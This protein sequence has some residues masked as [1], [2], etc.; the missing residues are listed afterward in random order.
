MADMY[1]TSEQQKATA[2]AGA[3][4]AA[5]NRTLADLDARIKQ[6]AADVTSGI[7]AGMTPQELADKNA[8]LDA[9]KTQAEAVTRGVQGGYEFVRQE[10]D[11][12]AEQTARQ[13]AEAQAQQA[14]MARAAIQSTAG[15]GTRSGL[16]QP[17]VADATR[18]QE[19][20][21]AATQAYL[22]G[23]LSVAPEMLPRVQGLGTST[24]A[25]L[26]LA[27]IS[28]ADSSAF[29][30]AMTAVEAQTLAEIARDKMMLG[31]QIESSFRKEA[32]DR[33]ANQRQQAQAQVNQ[34]TQMLL[35]QQAQAALTQSQLE[36]AA[37]GADTRTGKQKAQAELETFK[38]QER[39]RH[40]YAMREIAARGQE[41]GLSPSQ[42]AQ[43][44]SI[45]NQQAGRNTYLNDML[46][47]AQARSYINAL[48]KSAVEAATA[49]SKFYSDGVTVYYAPNGAEGDSVPVNVQALQTALIEQAGATKNLPDVKQRQEAFAQWYTQ[50]DPAS[51]LFLKQWLGSVA[52]QLNVVAIDS[53]T[54]KTQAYN[55]SDPNTIYR[56]IM[57]PSVIRR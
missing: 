52:K 32:R 21:A 29:T 13:L 17:S 12:T 18:A 54:K 41:A 4:G 3:F 11:I 47:S 30:R 39:I 8:E 26:G 51:K 27:G 33:E 20:I 35:T 19:R 46:S 2:A 55:W 38:E 28:R 31:T 36:A 49:K 42:I 25:E 6:I 40:N 24:G 1:G 15:G 14:A 37:A 57:L 53:K 16:Y 56:Y 45:V 10:A 23:N 7:V 22:G 48:P 44:Q 9:L 50:V 34:L 43:Q 5:S